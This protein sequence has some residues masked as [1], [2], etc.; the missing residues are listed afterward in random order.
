MSDLPNKSAVDRAVAAARNNLSAED[1][2]KIQRLAQNR[3]A[4]EKMTAGLSPKD[5]ATVNR[6]LNDPEMLRKVLGSSRGKNALHEFL[7]K[8]P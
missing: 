6:V 7:K 3:D 2:A 4:L 5:W 1:A 8:M